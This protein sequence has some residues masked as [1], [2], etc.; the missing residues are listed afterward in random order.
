MRSI[1]VLVTLCGLVCL[2]A[3][4]QT[5]KKSQ[6]GFILSGQ[7][8]K[9]GGKKI[10]LYERAF[11]KTSN[12][13][14]STKAD[15]SGKFVFRGLVTEPTYYMLKTDVNPQVIGFYL[16]NRPMRMVGHADSLYAA[17]ITGSPEETIRQQYDQVYQ[18]FNF[19]A[20][21]EKENLAR[22]QGDTTALRGLKKQI[23]Q[24]AHQRK[25]ALA[26]L[27]RQYPLATAS[28]NQVSG[29]IASRQ[30]VDLIVADSL[31]RIYE[32]SS[33]AQAGQVK[34]FRNDWRIAQKTAIGAPA[35]D[36]IQPDSAGRP[37]S[38]SS[39]KGR[40]VLV[41]FWAS[42]CGPCRQESPFL[43]KAH[44]DF[45]PKNFTILSVSLDKNRSSWLKAIA[46]DQLNWT[47][48]SDLKFWANEA[49]RRYAIGSIPFNMVVD[50]DGKILALNLRG[51]SLYDFL[52]ANLP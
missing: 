35:L 41:D 45:S 11:Y 1:Y 38:L 50:P 28:V 8:A 15:P 7:L 20:L 44:Q 42:W 14:D 25:L 10:Y 29:Y 12:R 49:A 17:I 9:A 43:V 40:Y 32:A 18:R 52:K 46:D 48:V 33:I 23:R 26:D 21:E 37:I 6:P 4:A 5:A 36:F 34:A 51:D 16:E 30:A 39:F 47:H 2:S 31:L 3:H 22:S 24:L 13:V 27:M 19:D